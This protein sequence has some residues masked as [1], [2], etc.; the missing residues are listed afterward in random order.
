MCGFAMCVVEV[1]INNL[2]LSKP[3]LKLH[4]WKTL[5]KYKLGDI[6]HVAAEFF[7]QNFKVKF[8]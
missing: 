7:K 1:I 8:I 6:L 5:E 3:S 2:P 4:M